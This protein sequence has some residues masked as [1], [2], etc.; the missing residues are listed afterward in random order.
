MGRLT[1][2]ERKAR[3]A[4]GEALT[5]R[6]GDIDILTCPKG[7]SQHF[8]WDAVN[9][10][11]EGLK[12]FGVRVT[13]TG[14]KTFIFQKKVKA[15]NGGYTTFRETLGDVGIGGITLEQARIAAG[16]IRLEAKSTGQTPEQARRQ[17]EEENLKKAQQTKIEE[18]A[19]IE[20][21]RQEAER[22]S[23]LTLAKLCEAYW[24]HLESKGKVS[25]RE[26]RN[27]L[28]KNVIQ[29]AA[30]LAAK[31]ANEVT[32][33]EISDLLRLMVA[34]GV[35]REVGK[36]RSYL[37]AAYNLA[38]KSRLS[39]DIPIHFK[40]FGVRLNPAAEVPTLSVG[41][42]KARSRTL[43]KAELKAYVEAVGAMANDV[44]KDV[45]L[46]QLYTGGQRF[47][48]LARVRRE[49]FDP[50]TGVVT[51]YDGK[52]ARDE[53]RVHALPLGTKGIELFKALD[54]AAKAKGTTW[55]F[56]SPFK[57]EVSIDATNISKAGNEL[58]AKMLA[59]GIV[60][61]AF[62]LR[63]IR[64]TTETML[65]AAKVSKDV[66]AQLQ[67]HGISGVQAKHYDQHDYNEEKRFA[68][69]KWEAIISAATDGT[70]EGGKVV[71]LL[72][73]A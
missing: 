17:A 2:A 35:T 54:A 19:K 44:Y 4:S 12:G 58:A 28:T 57:K 34:N 71:S 43:D 41:Q 70:P 24:V 64:R 11:G 69:E 60:K 38:K 48:Q 15:P 26:A 9:D 31:P 5:I 30:G 23:N 53:D 42:G 61:A 65:A 73:S 68:L 67:S 27:C 22:V 7:K 16:A 14:H 72:R 51:L 32:D 63:D 10:K 52:G 40:A 66:R 50:H 25:A 55:L 6:Q 45:L 39:A 21:L 1:A 8:L 59:D 29:D 18:Q 62:E 3:L 37:I 20:A 46:A 49:N 13:P 33:E 56:P 47:A 36:V